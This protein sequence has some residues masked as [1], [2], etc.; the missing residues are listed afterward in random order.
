VTL[1][2]NDKPKSLVVP[3]DLLGDVTVEVFGPDGWVRGVNSNSGESVYAN[4]DLR[5]NLLVD[6]RN[7]PACKINIG[8]LSYA[9]AANA[10]TGFAFPAPQAPD[11][12]AVRLDDKKIGSIGTP[13]ELQKHEFS[14]LVDT[15][16]KRAH[17]LR[18]IGY[19]VAPPIPGQKFPGSSGPAQPRYFRPAHFHGICGGTIHYFLTPAPGSVNTGS[20]TGTTSRNELLE[21][22][23]NQL[24]PP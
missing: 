4:S 13:K 18:Q 10:T 5:V 7:A 20:V 23:L 22:P 17:A 12:E 2:E 16:A 6:N 3:K 19:S 24:P 11:T 8:Q 9:V 1:D 15:S 21:V 14:Y